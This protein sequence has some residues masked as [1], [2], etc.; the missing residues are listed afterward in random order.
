MNR[1]FQRT[2]AMMPRA[3]LGFLPSYPSGGTVQG[4]WPP[5]TQWDCVPIDSG[6][7][8][9]GWECSP[10]YPQTTPAG[11]DAGAVSNRNI[12]PREGADDDASRSPVAPP[13]GKSFLSEMAASLGVSETTLMGV[14]LIGGLVLV[15]ALT[16]KKG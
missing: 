5:G 6:G 7:T 4:D 1:T 13:K 15:L 9:Q 8:A 2:I 14:G 11:Y 10:I 16:K 12:R 3:G